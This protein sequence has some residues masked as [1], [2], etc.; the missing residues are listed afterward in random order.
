MKARKIIYHLIL[1]ITL[2]ITTQVGGLIWLFSAFVSYRLKKKKRVVFPVVYLICNIVIVPPIAKILGRER[3]PVF[4]DNIAPINWS[5]PLLFRNY[6]NQELKTLLLKSS[7]Q[8]KNQSI[9][10]VYLDAN[11]PFFNGFPLL[12]H[13]SHN[14][15]KKIDLSFMYLDENNNQTNNKPS[16][17]GYGVYVDDNYSTVSNCKNDGY[18]Q[19]D[20]TK[21]IS[22]GNNDKLKFDEQR[23]RTLIMSFVNKPETQKVFIEPYLKRRLKLQNQGKIRFQGCKAVRHDDHVHLQIN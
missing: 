15:G 6:A 11:F 22:F 1:V 14:D 20:I 4:N 19:Y 7:E 12:P 2:T 5:Y 17:S 3:L 18:W 8:L 21:Y 13:L 10:I 9:K 16:T 23:T